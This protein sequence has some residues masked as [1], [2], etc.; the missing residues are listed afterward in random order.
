MVAK[1][2]QIPTPPVPA[3][4][5]GE[6]N[7]KASDVFDGLYR[8][9]PL[10]NQLGEEVEA[11]GQ[12]AGDA[13]QA[14]QENSD[15]A[16]RY[17]NEANYANSLAQS[18]ADNA[19]AGKDGAEVAKRA[20]EV[21]AERA[22]LAAADAENRVPMTS[23]TGVALLPE[24]SDVQRPAPG[25]IPAG[26]LAARGSTQDPTDYKVEFW[27]RVA[28]VW[29][30]FADRAWVKDWVSQKVGFAIIYPNGGSQA[31]PANAAINSRYVESNPFP[32][33]SVICVPEV[34]SGGLWGRAG[35]GQHNDLTNVGV[36]YSVGIIADQLGDSIAI[37][38]GV[39]GLLG[40]SARF[41]NPF[42]KTDFVFSTSLPFRVKVFKVK[43]GI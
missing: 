8:A 29:K 32:G 22:A 16:L 7:K 6:F 40:H 1:V 30:V 25:S 5:P 24:G 14:A 42:N 3:D 38:T 11:I 39:S 4:P 12:A 28:A 20:A 2:P 18:A 19:D 41:G 10:I 9:I 43:G 35:F 27:D 36:L 26:H 17:R 23:G 37:Q 31:A 13:S 15:A 33:E 21:A 34:Y